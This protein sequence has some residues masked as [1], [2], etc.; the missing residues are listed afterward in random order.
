MTDGML[1]PLKSNLQFLA[2]T[3]R[4]SKVNYVFMNSYGTEELFDLIVWISE[5]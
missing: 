5:N 1:C 4:L 3:G 2:D